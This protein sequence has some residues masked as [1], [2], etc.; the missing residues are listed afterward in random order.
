M[1]YIILST[2]LY[3]SGSKKKSRAFTSVSSIEVD[4]TMESESFS[5]SSLLNSGNVC[6]SI[7]FDHYKGTIIRI[8]VYQSTVLVWVFHVSTQPFSF[9]L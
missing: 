3:Y 8:I 6:E 1:L 2:I 7:H 4:P 9:F 5:L